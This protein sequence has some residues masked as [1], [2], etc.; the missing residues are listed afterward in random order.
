MKQRLIDLTSLE[1]QPRGYALEAWLR[2]AFNI[3]CLETHEAFRNKGEQI[4]GSFVLQGETY[5]LAAKWQSAKTP[6]ADLQGFQ[7]KLDQKAA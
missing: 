7:G 3:Y 1:P 4:D 2:D 6:A 5:L